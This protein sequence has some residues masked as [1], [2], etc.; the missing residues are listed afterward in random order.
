MEDVRA[1]GIPK[2]VVR[3]RFNNSQP[4]M[5]TS[6]GIMDSFRMDRGVRQSDGQLRQ[7]M[8]N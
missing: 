2:K 7:T 5:F 3:L 6:D 1:M 8:D 4:K